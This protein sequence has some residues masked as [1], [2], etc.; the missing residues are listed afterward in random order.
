MTAIYY[1]RRKTFDYKE[2]TKAID[3]NP[4][5]AKNYLARGGALIR[6]RGL[7]FGFS[8]FNKALKVDPLNYMAYN[9]R[10][11]LYGI[12]GD[13]KKAFDD[14]NKAIALKP[15]NAMAYIQKA[16]I[17]ESMQDID[18][19]LILF[20]KAIKINPKLPGAYQQRGLLYKQI[21]EYHKAIDDFTHSIS[22]GDAFKKA[23]YFQRGECYE[24]LKQ[25]DMAIE[26]FN[27]SLKEDPYDVKVLNELGFVYMMKRNYEKGLGEYLTKSLPCTPITKTPIL[28]GALFISSKSNM[29]SAL[30]DYTDA[31]R[32]GALSLSR[33]NY[34]GGHLLCYGR[35]EKST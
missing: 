35:K 26:D 3:K 29:I 2:L 20:D 33:V 18:Q 13:Y 31:I 4:F 25:F 23:S 11:Q 21:G 1:S 24:T 12:K 34:T 15:D 14:F 5:K 30:K 27:R 6:G 17:L 19:A 32:T 16:S 7:F 22:A 9:M 28:T 8:D 10:G